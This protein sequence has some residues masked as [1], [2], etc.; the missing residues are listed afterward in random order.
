MRAPQGALATASPLHTGGQ[1][2]LGPAKM[3]ADL[4]STSAARLSELALHAGQSA[5]PQGRPEERS[6]CSNDFPL[7]QSASG[8]SFRIFSDTEDCLLATFSRCAPQTL[9][10]GLSAVQVMTDGWGNMK[11]RP[12][13]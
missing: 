3:V 9:R 1:V 10:C 7:L 6:I 5:L 13:Q 4:T 8:S 11:Q 12:R 2:P